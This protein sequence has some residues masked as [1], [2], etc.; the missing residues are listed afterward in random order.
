MRV[1]VER[2]EKPKRAECCCWLIKGERGY[3][4]ADL[5]YLCGEI[6]KPKF[7]ESTFDAKKYYDEKKAREKAKK[8]GCALRL[9]DA[10]NGELI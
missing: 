6:V 9:Y 10:I 2:E 7:C 8:L 4:Q 5:R 1:H 3:F